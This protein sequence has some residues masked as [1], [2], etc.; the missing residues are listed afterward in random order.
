VAP[1]CA[2]KV[3]EVVL[4][5]AGVLQVPA[6]KVQYWNLIEPTFPV[7]GR[8]NWKKCLTTPLGLEPPSLA[9]ASS[10]KLRFVICA[11]EAVPENN[12]S[13]SGASIKNAVITINSFDRFFILFFCFLLNWSNH[14]ISIKWQSICESIKKSGAVEN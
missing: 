14:S 12:P 5:P 2:D 7:V 4:K 8:V 13:T 1:V 3:A 6:A 11:A 9:P 10:V